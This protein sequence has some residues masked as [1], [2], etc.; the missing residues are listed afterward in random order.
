ML[1]LT[2]LQLNIMLF[3]KDYIKKNNVIV[4]QKDIIKFMQYHNIKSYNTLFAINAL[5][6]KGYIRKAVTLHQNRTYYVMIR[7]I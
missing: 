2:D 4:P 6:N 3:V 1:D 7:N 5:I